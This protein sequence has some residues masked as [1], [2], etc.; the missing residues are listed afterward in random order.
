[1]GTAAQPLT[2]P[3]GIV[4]D[5]SVSGVGL[6]GT[7]NQQNYTTDSGGTMLTLGRPVPAPLVVFDPMVFFSPSGR[8]E[9][10]SSTV[11]GSLGALSVRSIRSTCS[12]GEGT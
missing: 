9:W 2:F 12:W 4:I 3:Q 6:T 1:M 8:L 10:V 5:L 11:P 7:F